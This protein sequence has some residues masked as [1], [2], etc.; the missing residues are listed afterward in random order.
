MTG[1]RDSQ[2]LRQPARLQRLQAIDFALQDT[3]LYLDAYPDDKEALDYY[4]SLLSTRAELLEAF[5][6]DTPL[7][8]YD[9]LGDTWDWGKNPW[10]WELESN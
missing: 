9:N 7:T 2:N 6:Q 5:P 1:R 10:P 4:H 8:V 3:V